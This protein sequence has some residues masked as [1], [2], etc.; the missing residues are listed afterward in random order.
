MANRNEEDFGFLAI[1]GWTARGYK[2]KLETSAHLA[3]EVVKKA[4]N[5]QA[6]H[7]AEITQDVFNS[8]RRLATIRR[9]G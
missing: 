1:M 6:Q 7:G 2:W 3:D 4:K 8:Y 5:F 9:K